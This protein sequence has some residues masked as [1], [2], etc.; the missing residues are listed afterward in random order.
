MAKKKQPYKSQLPMMTHQNQTIAMGLA[1]PYILDFSGCG[2]GKTGSHIIT[3]SE[4]LSRGSGDEKLLVLAPKSLLHSAW[5]DDIEKF[6][7]WL[8]YSVATAANREAA[9]ASD[10]NVYIT[11]I[12]YAKQLAT[13]FKKKSARDR[14]VTRG[15]MFVIDESS[16][17]KHATSARS[18]GAATISK[19][20]DRRHLMTGTPNSRSI[21]DVW[22]QA[23]IADGGKRL[24]NSFYQFR[25]QVSSPL[26]IGNNANA[27][28]WTDLPGAEQ[29]V[30][31]LLQDIVIRHKLE[32]CVDIP[33]NNSYVVKYQLTTKQRKIYETMKEDAL[34]LLGKGKSISALNA[35]IVANKL[36]QISSGAVYDGERAVHVVEDARIELICDLIDARAHSIVVYQWHHQRDQLVVALE[37]N[38]WPYAVIDSSVSDTKRRE[39]VRAM[40]AGELK[41]LIGHPASMGHGLTLT[42]ATATIWASPTFNAE[43][44]EQ[45]LHR[46]YRKGQTE[47]TENI[48]VVAENTYDE[49]AYETSQNRLTLMHSLLSLAEK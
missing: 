6:A 33:P 5:G 27:I 2:T 12:D 36:L 48:F 13:M 3:F 14:L 18:K 23:F 7:P 24:G 11:N 42:R 9:F 30:M 38:K 44:V 28:Q 16:S 41:V 43:M 46:V 10:A 39:A 47:R 22:H 1:E 31:A 4:M 26:Q 29:V 37:K 15:S 35:A 49:R 21:T 34:V 8:K 40:Q 17:V 19:W 32:D 25:N 45:V 20:F